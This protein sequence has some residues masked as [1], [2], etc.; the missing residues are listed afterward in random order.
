MSHRQIFVLAV[1]AAGFI[2]CGERPDIQ[3]PTSQIQQG[4][5]VFASTYPLAYFAE[6]ILGSSETVAF[7][8]MD[9]DPAFWEPSAEDVASM[10]QAAVILVNGATYEKW[11]EGV[12][13]PERKIIDTSAPFA[14]RY[15]TVTGAISHSHGPGA[16]HAHAGTAFI[17]WLD[18]SLAGAQAS[19]VYSAL[20]DAGI[21][22][23]TALRTNFAALTE[24]LE[25]LDSELQTL[26]TGLASV[27][28]V[29]SHPV[30]DYLANRYRLNIESAL[31]EP[32][33]FPDEHQWE[34]LGDV[35]K[36]HPAKW[37]I[38]EGQPAEESVERLMEMGIES[39]VFDPAGNRS[40][41]GDF[42]ETMRQNVENLRS[43]LGD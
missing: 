39:V 36:Q 1:V 23:E 16:E 10:Q 12:T 25:S 9:G 18:F 34:L 6:R 4:Q 17:T 24:D 13:L 42:L 8:E 33:V 27:P 2:A 37:M 26:A 32:D 28:I 43:I 31:W 40:D 22:D 35:L 29:A 15:L 30:Y 5:S 20:S 7:P 38:W 14:D 21:G 41:A 3:H 19:V 11:L